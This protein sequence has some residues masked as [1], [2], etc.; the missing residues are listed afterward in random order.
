[1]GAPERLRIRERDRNL[2]ESLTKFNRY[3]FKGKPSSPLVRRLHLLRRTRSSRGGLFTDGLR[4]LNRAP[5]QKC[6]FRNRT[7]SLASQDYRWSTYAFPWAL[8]RREVPSRSLLLFGILTSFTRTSS[9]LS[10]ETGVL[11]F[12]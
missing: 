12:V 6:R 4:P 7:S 2:P 10:L 3:L 8:G 11:L 9:F 1:M 5:T